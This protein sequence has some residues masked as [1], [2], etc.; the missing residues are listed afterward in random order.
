MN[1]RTFI[2][3]LA[4]ASLSLLLGR[5]AWAQI[6]PPSLPLPRIGAIRWDAWYDPADGKVA[7][8]VERSLGPAEFHYRMPFFGRE[9]GPN[10]VRINGDSQAIMDQEIAAAAGRASPTGLS[11]PTRKAIR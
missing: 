2:S 5:K 10:S 11:A 4:G 9:T 3:G 1:R 7:Q 6:A 8:A